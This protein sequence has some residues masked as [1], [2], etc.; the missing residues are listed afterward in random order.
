MTLTFDQC[1]GSPSSYQS[2]TTSQCVWNLVQWQFIWHRDPS[3]LEAGLH[4]AVTPNTLKSQ[5]GPLCER[6]HRM[7][8]FSSAKTGR[9]S[10]S[11][12]LANERQL[13]GRSDPVLAVPVGRNS[14]HQESGGRREQLFDG[15][16]VPLAAPPARDPSPQ[17]RA[18]HHAP[19]APWAERRLQEQQ[20]AHHRRRLSLRSATSFSTAKATCPRGA[21]PPKN[22][23]AH[24]GEVRSLFAIPQSATERPP[25]LREGSEVAGS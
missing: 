9:A 4:K 20:T 15:A 10:A 6:D 18:F 12:T 1:R 25:S 3:A 13:S 17:P 7:S 22:I 21:P 8:Q 2:A 24:L 11:A 14:R 23:R 5:S 19:A 16:M